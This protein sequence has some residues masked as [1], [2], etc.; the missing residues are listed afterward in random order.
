VAINNEGGGIYSSYILNMTNSTV[1]G[2]Q[3]GSNGGGL[4][5]ANS[6]I[7]SSTIVNNTAAAG[8]N[9]YVPTNTTTLSRS[10][11]SVGGCTVAVGASLTDGSNNIAFNAADCPGANVDP[12][13]GILGAYGGSTQTMRTSLGS[14]A[15][16]AY[17]SNC[18]STDQRGNI[19]PRGAACD[20]GAYEANPALTVTNLNDSGTGSLRDTV[21]AAVAGDTIVFNI[22]GTVT[23]T[24]GEMVINKSLIIDGL[25]HS[26]TISGNNASRIFSV[27]NVPSNVSIV[28]FRNL[29]LLNGNAGFATGGA[30]HNNGNLTLTNATL[31]NNNATNMS[32]SMQ[33]GAIFNNGTLTINSS[34]LNGNT[35][36]YGGAIYNNIGTLWIDNSSL[37]GNTGTANG[38]AIIN[39]GGTIH[40]SNSSVLNNTSNMN[41]GGIFNGNILNVTNSTF[42]NN[43]ASMAGGALYILYQATI[44]SSTFISNSAT[45]GAGNIHNNFN[46]SIR[47]SILS[48]GSCSGTITDGGNNI[49]FNASGCP[50]TNV[51]PLLGTLGNYGGVT[52]T[53]PLLEGSPAIDAY[54]MGCPAA[55]QRGISRPQGVSCD[56]G[57]FEFEETAPPTTTIVTEN[58]FYTAVESMLVSY[59]DINNVV[60]DFVPNALN[61]T[62]I[63][64]TGVV[65]NVTL[66]ITQEQGFVSF[67][68]T[69]I[70][71]NGAT[72]PDSYITII[73]RD[74][75]LIL[76]TALDNLVTARFGDLV[77]VQSITVTNSALTLSLD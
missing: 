40:I 33:G 72:A 77:D 19:R 34:N 47:T 41:G 62:V 60:I 16:D 25:G 36:A 51:D 18:L 67:N 27:N 42:Y 71:V 76:T 75:P 61:L 31:I 9:I 48:G 74:L 64:R 26:V 52:Q 70:T 4:Y 55:D 57:A 15:I 11:I 43:S 44:S 20:I 12:Q 53:I 24:S 2:N 59:P 38:G 58:E 13:L 66:T 63:T 23:L 69:S 21:S 22:G 29:T 49:A 68:I 10:I 65:G 1:T 45:S 5:S 3:A 50:G 46:T 14:P 30:I 7:D 32:G 56:I 37:S 6:N 54:S 35:A 28:E 73:N 39:S 17:S 8:A